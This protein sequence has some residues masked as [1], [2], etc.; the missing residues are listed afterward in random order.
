MYKKSLIAISTSL[1]LTLT[2]CGGSGGGDSE[3]PL[4]VEDTIPA[5]FSFASV[6]DAASNTWIESQSITV[7]GISAATDISIS[8]GEYSV[9]DG[10]FTSSAGQVNSGDNVKVRIKSS[11]M[12]ATSTQLSLTIGG[13]N[14]TFIV[15]TGTS[16]AGVIVDINFDTVHSVGGVS[17]FSREKFI[18]IHADITENGWR[19]GNVHSANAENEDPNLLD[20]F[21]NGYDVYFGRNTGGMTW[22][23]SQIAEDAS[24][25]GF[26]SEADATSRG[27]GQKWGFNNYTG[28]HWDTIRSLQHRALGMVVGAQQHPYWPD[29]TLTAQGWALSQT[30]TEAEPFGTATG[31][32][33]GQYVSKY[34]DPNPDDNVANGQIKPAYVEVMN[35]PLYDLVT[36]R[37]GQS[38]Q[39]EPA[40]IFEFHNAVANEIRKTNPDVQVGGYTVAF[41]NF[42]W[43]NFERWEERDK[44]FIDIAGENM[45]F[46][47]IHLYDFP[48]FQNK[49]QYRKGSNAEA[50]M[51]MLE[52]YSLLKFGET[53]PLV[54]SE[55]GAAIHSMFKQGWNPER[56]TLQMRAINSMLMQFMERPDM[57]L[58]T[59][60]FIVVKAE[61]G[62]TE[63]PYGPRLMVQ[64]FERDGDAA[65]DKW[66]Y[67][68]LIQFYQLWSE[69]NGTRIETKAS[70]L[71]IQVD[72]YIDDKTAHIILNSLEFTDTDI[73]L[74]AFGLDSANI[75]EVEVKHL[76]T[77]DNAT[78]ASAIVESAYNE[79]PEV[80]T[81]GA[82][83]TMIVKVTFDSAPALDKTV[84]ETKYYGESYKQAIV[85]NDLITNTLNGVVLDDHGE[86]ILRLG[87]GR[88]HGKSLL[89]EVSIN[90]TSLNVPEDFRGYDQQMGK[91]SAA[92]D[93][94]YG[95]IEI[96]VPYSALAENNDISIR[97]SDTGGFVASTALQVFN[98]EQ[99]LGRTI[100]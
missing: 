2:G 66:V 17:E 94:F 81:L 8:G 13:V 30:D 83:S 25:P 47:A 77:V 65:G 54:I 43:D 26:A 32:Y 1:A 71:D 46:Y 39:V 4:K 59:I 79:L 24:R 34:F 69:V 35:E 58:K 70:D 37:E 6:T 93:G 87:I 55:Y 68:D 78:Q 45:D 62:R 14:A 11:T 51:D 88:D 7:T 22:Q 63:V 100:Q 41:P 76:T 38:D 60:P 80:I 40:K 86:A 36:D 64:K 27:N 89:P 74:N 48:A 56:N 92:R 50:T 42:D 61:W 10:D 23:L 9:N 67:S 33:M 98:A 29:G 19:G 44:A 15:T 75:T 73:N 16:F 52:H 96:P 91:S 97:F 20:S 53:R 99:P 18:T 49:E 21:A 72:A 5:Q 57:I 28:N 82:E 95:V 31:H 12:D 84:A 90:G 3:K 85:A